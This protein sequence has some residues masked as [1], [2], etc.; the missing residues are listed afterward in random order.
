MLSWSL[1]CNTISNCLIVT[2]IEDFGSELQ[3]DNGKD[4][5][6]D[7]HNPFHKYFLDDVKNK[8]WSRQSQDKDNE[9]DKFIDKDRCR[10]DKKKTRNEGQIILKVAEW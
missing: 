2:I 8:V 1:L 9:R 4:N 6:K 10:D 7:G 5:Y 3:Q